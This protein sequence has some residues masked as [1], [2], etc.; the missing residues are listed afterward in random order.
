MSS[1][2]DRPRSTPTVISHM[3]LTGISHVITRATDHLDRGMMIQRMKDVGGVRD[4]GIVRGI[5]RKRRAHPKETEEIRIGRREEDLPGNIV[6]LFV[7]FLTQLIYFNE[8]NIRTKHRK[9]SS[10]CISVVLSNQ[11]EMF[12][13]K[14]S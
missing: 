13:I 3:I 12:I 7:V 2:I 8:H 11:L 9:F 6:C 4:I 10:R 5:V 14:M 1:G